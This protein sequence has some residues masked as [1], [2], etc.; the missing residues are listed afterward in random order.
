M[1]KLL[2]F[3]LAT[4]STLGVIGL[5]ASPAAFARSHREAP[6]C[7]SRIV[8]DCD[9]HV[10]SM[11]NLKSALDCGV[12]TPRSKKGRIGKTRKVLGTRWRCLRGQQSIQ[13]GL[14]PVLV[15]SP[16]HNRLPKGQNQRFAHSGCLNITPALKNAI[17]RCKGAPYE[18]RYASKGHELGATR[19]ASRARGHARYSEVAELFHP[20]DTDADQ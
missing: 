3:Y 2:R 13:I 19:Y 9:H 6:A 14:G 12:S 7:G 1:H 4:I 18:I 17:A 16:C 15:H 8:F 10:A 11:G 20:D 5:M